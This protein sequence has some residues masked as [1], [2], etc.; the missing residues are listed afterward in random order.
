MLNTNNLIYPK[1]ITEILLK[2]VLNAI[3][4]LPLHQFIVCKIVPCSNMK[5]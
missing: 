4:S 5:T 1:N 3:T 2:A